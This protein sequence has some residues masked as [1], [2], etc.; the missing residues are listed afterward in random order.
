MGVIN[1]LRLLHQVRKNQWLK[2][3]ELEKLQV[4]KLR[5][6]IKH[7]YKNT[8][9]YHRKFKDAGIRPEDIKT[10]EDL[11]KIPFTTKAEV[12]KAFPEGIVSKNVDISKCRVVST[13]GSTGVPLKVVYDEQ[14]DDYSKAVNLRSFMENGL[15]FTSKWIDITNPSH[16]AEK[17]WFQY[18]GILSPKYLS[19]TMDVKSQVS[20]IKDFNPDVISGFS[21]SLLLIAKEIEKSGITEIKPI[22]VILII[23]LSFFSLA[24]RISGDETSLFMG[25]VAYWK[26]YETPFERHADNWIG[27]YLSNNST[28]NRSWSFRCPLSN[29]SYGLLPIKEISNQNKKEYFID[30]Q[31]ITDDSFILFS[32][33]DTTIGFPYEKRATGKYHIGSGSFIKLNTNVIRLL[34]NYERYYDNGMVNIYHK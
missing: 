20:I 6:M 8:E 15:K 33:F 24:S 5:A 29:V 30:T 2:T 16:I 1:K 23:F 26:L 25:D 27:S 34:D 18:L 4:K 32:K 21:S 3:S 28:V 19:T 7:A 12:R 22:V 14:A 10:V 11:K 9:F 13:G 17:K 31:N